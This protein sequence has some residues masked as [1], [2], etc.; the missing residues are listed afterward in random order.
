MLLGDILVD[1][2]F[3]KHIKII[4]VTYRSLFE[5]ELFDNNH[6]VF[7]FFSNYIIRQSISKHTATTRI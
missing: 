3:N 2:S 4:A 5:L 1:S 6:A 7:D